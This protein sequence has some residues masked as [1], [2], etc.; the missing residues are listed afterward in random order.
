MKTNMTSP[1]IL[2]ASK[3]THSLSRL[4]ICR[5]VGMGHFEHSEQLLCTGRITVSAVSQ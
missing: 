1:Q 2:D 3:E 4:R 5:H